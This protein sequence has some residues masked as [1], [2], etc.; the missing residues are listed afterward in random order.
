M[1]QG[2]LSPTGTFANVTGTR[3]VTSAIMSMPTETNRIANYTHGVID[4]S[5]TKIRSKITI[6]RGF[7]GVETTYRDSAVPVKSTL[8]YF[9]IYENLVPA[10]NDVSV[11]NFRERTKGVGQ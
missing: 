11:G 8:L 2:S 7:G 9:G 6:I 10:G 3:N 5:S 1:R 4:F